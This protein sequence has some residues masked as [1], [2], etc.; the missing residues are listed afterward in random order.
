M[1]KVYWEVCVVDI[2]C[3]LYYR[4]CCIQSDGEVLSEWRLVTVHVRSL[5]YHHRVSIFVLMC[6]WNPNCIVCNVCR[7]FTHYYGEVK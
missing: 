5:H 1:G 2:I 3:V 6:Q 7:T 4:W